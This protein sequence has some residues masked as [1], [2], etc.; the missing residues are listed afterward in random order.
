MTFLKYPHIVRL[1]DLEVDGLTVGQCHVF[2][3][4][5]GT[6]ASIWIDNDSLCFG[7]RNRQL[8][9][10]N[11]NAGFMNEMMREDNE[12]M[13]RGF[14]RY[15]PDFRL[16]GEWLVP[17]SLKTYR[18]DAWRRFYVF[19]VW[20]RREQRFLP[21][22]Q[23]EPIMKEFGFEYIPPLA[24]INN[25]TAVDLYRLLEK[26]GWFL[27]KDGAGQGEGIV[28]KN[29][30]F[31]NKHGR[32][33]WGKIV[34]NEFKERHY[35]EMGAPIINNTIGVE[36]KIVDEYVTEA[37]VLKEKAKIELAN[38]GW[39]NKS[40]PELLGRV[41][42]ELVREETHNFVKKHNQPTISFR[43][44]NILTVK[45]VKGVIGL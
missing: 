33:T 43:L 18:E 3:K 45:K 32:T 9:L 26:S 27:V 42:Y 40:I 8:S 19:D 6:N 17:H 15:H 23:Y 36:Q 4:I 11:D 35:K 16:Y 1:D 7:S 29:Y 21:Y 10:D 44:L 12:E 28:I 30:D 22:E 37:L 13:L 31:V 38:G 14:F 20:D 39:S 5:D 24:I 2:Y 25:P 34:T 41:F